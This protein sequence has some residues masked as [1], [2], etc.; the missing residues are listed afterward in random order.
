M[1]TEKDFGS[2][3]V[4]SPLQNSL[5][6][7]GPVGHTPKRTVEVESHLLNFHLSQEQLAHFLMLRGS[8]PKVQLASRLLRRITS[9]S[10]Y[11]KHVTQH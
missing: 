11:V 1:V 10:M 6:K 3:A 7:L 5:S 8:F 4:A 9:S 2:S